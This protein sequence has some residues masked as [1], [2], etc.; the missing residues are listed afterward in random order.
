MHMK[1]YAFKVRIL[2]RTNTVRALVNTDVV[3]YLERFLFT[4]LHNF[5]A[6]VE[7]IENIF[8]GQFRVYKIALSWTTQFY[9]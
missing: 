5:P 1:K 2:I 4:D 8:Y 9:N 3:V 7:W 6:P